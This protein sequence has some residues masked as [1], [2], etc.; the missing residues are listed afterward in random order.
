MTLAVSSPRRR[1]RYHGLLAFHACDRVVLAVY[2]AV[3]S[4]PKHELYG[5]SQQARR[6]AFSTAAN[7]A[8]GAGKR[9][10]REF[11]R[12]LDISLG[13]LSEL[14]YILS[15]AVRLKYLTE[16][17]FNTLDDLLEEAGKLTYSLARSIDKRGTQP[18]KTESPCK[19]TN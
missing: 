5:L 16:D 8:E 14:S 9:G 12:F 13:S 15:L 6:C 19:V 7:I 4:W 18:P 2:A 3:R 10:Y 1:K 17:E 11:R